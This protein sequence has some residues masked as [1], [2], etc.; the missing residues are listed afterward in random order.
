M[1][2]IRRTTRSLVRYTALH[3]FAAPFEPASPA[4]EKRPNQPTG[5]FLYVRPGTVRANN[6][7]TNPLY[8]LLMHP[9]IPPCSRTS[10]R[11]KVLNSYALQVRSGY[12]AFAH[13]SRRVPG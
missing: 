7:R 4:Q 11:S 1:S 5:R 13:R 12:R 10:H 2:F 8:N 6:S 3:V 9:Q